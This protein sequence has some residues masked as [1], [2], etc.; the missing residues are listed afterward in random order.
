M[1]HTASTS[2]ATYH[3]IKRDGTLSARQ[4]QIMAAMYEGRDYSLQELV[5]L[6]GLP[7]NVISGRCN[8]LRNAGRLE[9]ADKRPCS[10]TGRT[11]APVMLVAAQ[12]VLL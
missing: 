5:H 2:I 4:E 11:V 7:I 9:L 10:V 6:T 3:A 12:G 8:E 1:H